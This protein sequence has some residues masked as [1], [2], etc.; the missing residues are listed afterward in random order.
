[1]AEAEATGA[2]S[3]AARKTREQ[4]EQQFQ[5]HLSA[6]MRTGTE[7]SIAAD[8]PQERAAWE[9]LTENVR[10]VSIRTHALFAENP[11]K[12]QA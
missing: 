12:E 9:A 2:A 8:N 7:L 4:R 10:L 1:M 5:D 3:V 6:A 11:N